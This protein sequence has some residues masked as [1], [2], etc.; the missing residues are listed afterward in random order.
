MYFHN[1]YTITNPL[2]NGHPSYYSYDSTVTFNNVPS[3]DDSGVYTVALHPTSN[4]SSIAYD[5]NYGSSLFLKFGKSAWNIF[6]VS[7]K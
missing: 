1:L 6:F 2:F 7:G 5:G 3:I 4:D